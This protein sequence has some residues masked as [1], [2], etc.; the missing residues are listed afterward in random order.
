MK[1][2][3]GALLLLAA[4]QAYA[5]AKL[6]QFPNQDSAAQVLIPASVAFL[7]VGLVLCFWGLFSEMRT[8]R[9]SSG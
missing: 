1:L 9:G 6:L 3:S 8:A 7:V 2:L 5:H 4:E